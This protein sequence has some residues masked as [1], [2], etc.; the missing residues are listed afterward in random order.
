VNRGV[1]AAYLRDLR[2]SLGARTT[3]AVALLLAIA[4]AATFTNVQESGN[5][6]PVEASALY[7]YESG[8]YHLSVWTYDAGGN[9]L[10]DV[11]ADVGGYTLG[12]TNSSIGPFP[13]S[14]DR[15]GELS[16]AIPGP[17]GPGVNL[18]FYFLSL[19]NFPS[20]T[21][22][23]YG[24]LQ[25]GAYLT[26]G[27]LTPGMV[28]GVNMLRDVGAN[29]YSSAAQVMAFEEGTNGSLPTAYHLEVCWT[30]RL[31]YPFPPGNCTGL[32]TQN[33]GPLTGV[34]THFQL[35]SFP[36]NATFAVTQLVNST[37]G[38]VATLGLQLFPTGVGGAQAGAG[39]P[40]TSILSIFGPEESFFLALVGLLGSYWIYAG[41]RLS[42]TVEPVLA[43][44]VTRRGLLL[45]RFAAVA[46]LVSLAAL[47]NTLLLDGIA[48]R[49]LGEPLPAS[50]VGPLIAAGIA[51]GLGL[52]ALI[53]VAS[54]VVRS[55][56][57]TIAVG[58]LLVVVSLFWTGLVSSVLP[59]LRPG[60]TPLE[61]NLIVIRSQYLLPTQFP[62]FAA[63]PGNE[64]ALGGLGVGEVALVA[65]A[66]ITIPL[67]VAYHRAV[68][69][70]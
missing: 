20:L 10:S 37:G 15:D 58:F 4:G 28:Y 67:T 60:L 47:V 63:E 6:F 50:L 42:G 32:P 51:A 35:P 61:Q 23:W 52:A 31:P 17:D 2:H 9:P 45:E 70:D 39:P 12:P 46:I 68:T 65:T 34:W 21:P 66:W 43:R 53:F 55:P 69:R 22:D 7:Y 62:E 11:R 30:W 26:L 19:G 56:G 16:V 5:P 25:A 1:L 44:P 33:L 14:T 27:N 18:T 59:T 54:H 38:I 8:A 49:L 41:P 64:M 24:F 48:S 36:A 13:V 29:F 40:G 57:T 3:I